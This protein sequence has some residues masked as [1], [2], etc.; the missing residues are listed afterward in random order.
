V[1]IKTIFFIGQPILY[2]IVLKG[3]AKTGLNIQ[4]RPEIRA[5]KG[6]F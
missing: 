4:N 2:T 1:Y 3:K 5:V 6:G